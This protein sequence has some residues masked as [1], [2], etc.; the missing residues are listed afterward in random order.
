MI[1]THRRVRAIAGMAGWAGARAGYTMAM[2]VVS[3]SLVFGGRAHAQQ[4]GA[5]RCEALA[6]TLPGRW[7]DPTT[8]LVSSR[9]SAAGP[10]TAPGMLVDAPPASIMLPEHCEV[11]GVMRERLGAGGQ[12]DAIHFHLRLP[13]GWNGG[14]FFQ[15]GAGSDGVVGDAL[16]FTSKVSPPALLQGVAVVSQDS[17]H[18]NANNSDPTRGG[19]VAFGFDRRDRAAVA[20]AWEVQSIASLGESATEPVLSIARF[21]DG[22]SESDLNLVGDAILSVC[23]ADDGIK[24]GLVS[25]FPSCTDA[26]ARPAI[27][28]KRCTA[29]KTASCLS[30]NQVIALERMYGGPRDSKGRALYSNWRQERGRLGPDAP[31]PLC[32]Y[33]TTAH[34]LGHGNIETAESFVCR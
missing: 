1:S 25:D 23:D 14:F 28:A 31:G 16:G 13:T 11:F 2:L 5:S 10:Y 9:L 27:E 22:F 3:W 32:A 29:R 33:P 24:D 20:E 15:G 7:P 12:H 6:T 21:A 26:R 8:R 34:Y 19:D 17:G 30:S 18:D 4:A